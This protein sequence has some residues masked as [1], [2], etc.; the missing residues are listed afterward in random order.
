MMRI[1]FIGAGQMA[2]HHLTALA[3]SGVSTTI[4][5]VYDRARD[6]AH[7]FA[8]LAGCR[9]YPTADALLAQGSP[10]IVHVCTP[11]EAHFESASAALERGAHVYVEKP[12]ALTERDARALLML[13]RERGL[14]VCAGHQLV[15]DPAFT[16]LMARARELGD[17]VQIDSHFTFRPMGAAVGRS[18]AATQARQ[19]VDILPHPLYSLVW[20]LEQLAL[21]AGSTDPASIRTE[22]CRT[23]PADVQ[24]ILRAGSIVG[25]LSVSL[26]ARPIASSLAITGTRGS[27]TCDFMRSI[28]VGAGNSGTEALEKVLNPFVEGAGL[29]RR[30]AVSTIKRITS[31]TSYAGL[32]QIIDAFYQAVANGRPSPVS[33]DHLLQVTRVFEPLAAGID[34]AAARQRTTV[35]IGRRA[36]LQVCQDG[37][38]EGVPDVPRVVVTGAR[39]FLG[40]EIARA[41]SPVRGIGRARSTDT[42]HVASWTAADLSQGL[43]ADA[44]A[45]AE[46]V[47]H[48]AAEVAGGYAEHQRNSIDATINLLR[49][50][51]SAR[52]R[53]LV[54][55]SS[56]SVIE[57]PRGRERQHEGTPRP[58]DARPYGAYTWG[59]C[60]QEDLL[61]REAAT[62]GIDTR[63][64]RP[65]ALID[66]NEPE[67]PGLMGRRVFGKWHLGLGRPGLPIAVCDVD[68]CA[69]AIAWCVRH[70]DEAPPV[71][72]LLDPSIRSRADLVAQMGMRGRSVRV[73]WVPISLI[74]AGVTAAR[75][76]LA[77]SR[78]RRPERMRTWSI[79][80]PRRYDARLASALLGAV[81]RDAS[82]LRVSGR[83]EP[84]PAPA[85]PV[86]VA[87]AGSRAGDTS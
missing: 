63:I 74:A 76:A 2:G 21:N 3:R 29:A 11:P 79:L 22:W 27:L 31:G 47:V 16:R 23:E 53:R 26:R 20:V 73:I 52:V 8:E 86:P 58:V 38:P 30:A 17:P 55:V 37:T 34:A 57:P 46:V 61:Q 72:N 39:G 12:F 25:R 64:I 65:G 42:P 28:V 59:K 35:A 77:L 68:R 33:P 18:T 13:A 32:P 10:E 7:A 78:G 4:V 51:H 40:A 50:M 1:A 14:L 45:G 81:Q 19:L 85:M 84:V 56:L 60:A 15:R 41:L 5:G 6:R 87:A 82:S 43:D 75:A 69:D 9:T 48:A 83:A 24:A 71:V 44:L 49:A 70:F 66:P 62:L 54:H 80:R 67:F 36:D